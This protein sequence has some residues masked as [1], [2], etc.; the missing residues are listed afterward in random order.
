[1]CVSVFAIYVNFYW[2]WITSLQKSLPSKGETSLEEGGEVEEKMSINIR[3]V[4]IT[5][6][7]NFFE[8]KIE[9]LVFAAKD[10][11]IVAHRFG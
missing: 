3:G 5:I 2:Y 8:C 9:R 1:M 10:I 11:I 6:V 7:E 4:N